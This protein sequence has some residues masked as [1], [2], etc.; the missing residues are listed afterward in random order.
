[1]LCYAIE[2]YSKD[3]Q[4]WF[5]GIDVNGRGD[6]MKTDN[7]WIENHS[8]AGEIEERLLKEF[9]DNNTIHQL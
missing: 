7:I 6:M 3:Y 8:H 2:F 4:I 9:I 5:T 1:M